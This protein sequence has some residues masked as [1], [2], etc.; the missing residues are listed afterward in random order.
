MKPD[1]DPVQYKITTKANWNTVAP[2]Y[3]YNWA[4]DK[5]GPFKSTTEL[6]RLAD[7]QP[8]DKVLD[9]A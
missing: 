4:N 1:F 2:E 3:H 5:V 6:V 8:D 9:I 7:I